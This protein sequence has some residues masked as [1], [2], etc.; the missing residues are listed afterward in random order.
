MLDTPEGMI[1]IPVTWV[2]SVKG[3]DI[4]SSCVRDCATGLPKRRNVG[5][6]KGTL[7]PQRPKLLCRALN[8]VS[9][10]CL[11]KRQ[12]QSNKDMVNSS[13]TAQGDNG[14][15]D[16]ERLVDSYPTCLEFLG[17]KQT[18][19]HDGQPA[20]SIPLDLESLSE[21]QSWQA[22][23]SAGSRTWKLEK[24][25]LPAGLN[26]HDRS[27]TQ[28]PSLSDQVNKSEDKPDRSFLD[29]DDWA[30]LLL[31][32]SDH[33]KLFRET[34]WQATSLG[35]LHSWPKNLR[36][37][38]Q[39][40]LADCRA[41]ALFWGPDR[42]AIYNEAYAPLAG[43]NHPALFGAPFQKLW[44]EIWENFADQ[45]DTIERT[46]HATISSDSVM[47]LERHA[48]LEE[49]WFNISL[50]P[51][52]DDMGENGGIMNTAQEVTRQ[53][54]LDRRTKIINSIAAPP[55]LRIESIWQHILDVL[56]MNEKDAPMAILYAFEESLDVTSSPSTLKLQGT[57]GVPSGHVATPQK[58]DLQKASNGFFPTLRKVKISCE[59]LVLRREDG[60]LSDI[61]LEGFSW[62]GFGEPC[63]DVTA[64]PLLA[65][66][67]YLL[68]F[69][70]SGL[71]P[72]RAFD[73]DHQQFVQELG[74]QL[75]AV[76]ASA[77][78]FDQAQ[79]REAR[80]SKELADSERR[81]RKMAEVAP[82][83]M[84]D[85][86]AEGMLSWANPQYYDITGHSTNSKGTIATSFN[87]AWG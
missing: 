59:P 55:D 67:D 8:L 4:T 61:L 58:V 13:T 79:K 24:K 42:V 64:I 20:L 46:G 19:D 41:V 82:V 69:L 26:D 51:V 75:T 2:H 56:E 34:D 28:H 60:S 44:P 6:Q 68:G 71:N 78:S 62:R 53:A 12:S 27:D 81:I 22:V 38:T 7:P 52:R 63:T 21:H 36:S 9:A 37:A 25:S 30:T 23:F 77:L 87:L 65:S 73:K 29:R 74:R 3:K 80:L 49:A 1:C 10:V 16:L 47:Y 40:M 14:S 84:I 18:A 50:A 48:Y 54:L 5:G 39:I 76:L 33:V 72:R 43:H 35:D 45:F 86:S 85:I 66:E 15:S 11:Y 70:I 32:D 17:I 57:L 31:P 83:G